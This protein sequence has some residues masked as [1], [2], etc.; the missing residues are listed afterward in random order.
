MGAP[1][2]R[3][4]DGNVERHA[5]HWSNFGSSR[6]RGNSARDG[7]NVCPQGEKGSVSWQRIA[8]H[9]KVIGY[10]QPLGVRVKRSGSFGLRGA[11]GSGSPD[12]AAISRSRSSS[13]GRPA[14][15]ST[16]IID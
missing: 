13:L 11:S 1:C 15:W 12:A 5:H 6:G 14:S 10:F 16:K 7:E 3:S 9:G 2:E 8:T 4:S